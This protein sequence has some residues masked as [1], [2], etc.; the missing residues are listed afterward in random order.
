M[1]PTSPRHTVRIS[2]SDVRRAPPAPILAWRTYARQSTLSSLGKRLPRV[3]F[4]TYG[5]GKTAR[6]AAG[7]G[8]RNRVHDEA[9]YHTSGPCATEAPQEPLSARC[10]DPANPG[11]HLTPRRGVKASGRAHI[12]KAVGLSP[13]VRE[14]G[15]R[16]SARR[17]PNEDWRPH[18]WYT[19]L[20]FA[21]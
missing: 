21:C 13:S 1:R 6:R 12:S 5:T 8:S 18:R 10:G 11:E 15:P 9:L 19:N 20:R 14:S 7:W 17:P 4:S 2:A 16:R 3:R